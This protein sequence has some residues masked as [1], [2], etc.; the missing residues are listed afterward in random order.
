MQINI[1]SSAVVRSQMEDHLR[2]GL[3]Y[4]S[5]DRVPVRH[6]AVHESHLIFDRLQPGKAAIRADQHEHL[7]AVGYETRDKIG[8]YDSGAARHSTPNSIRDIEIAKT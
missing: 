8:A 6:I 7:V 5:P 3:F 1:T 2:L 4:N